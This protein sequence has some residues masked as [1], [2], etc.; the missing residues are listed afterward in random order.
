MRIELIVDNSTA[1]S[2]KPVVGYM[3]WLSKNDTY[4]WANK[5]GK[6][7]PCSTVSNKALRIFTDRNG[8]TELAINGRV[9]Y[10]DSSPIDDTEL[11]AI[12][13]DLLPPKARHLWPVWDLSQQ[14]T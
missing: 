11:S 12:V 1:Q 8:L 5:P 4:N 7:W 13:S 10:D 14:G 6:C 2:V 3:L 9:D